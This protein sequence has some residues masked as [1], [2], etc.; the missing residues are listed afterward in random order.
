MTDT[1]TVTPTATETPPISSVVFKLTVRE[2]PI[3]GAPIQ[4]NSTTQ[5]TDRDGQITA[6]LNYGQYYSVSSGVEALSF[7]TLYD[8]GANFIAQSPVS[9]AATRLMSAISGPCRVLV[10]G[11]SNIYFT[12]VNTTERVLS[13]PLTNPSDDPAINL[14]LNSLYGDPRSPPPAPPVDFAPGTTGFAIPESYFASGGGWQFLGQNINV[15]TDPPVCTDRGI[16]GACEVI[17]ARLLRGPFDYTRQVVVNLTK[18]ALKAAKAG[19]WKGGGGA[20]SVPFFK[21][22]G[23]ALA[24]MEKSFINSSGQNFACEVTPMSCRTTKVPKRALARAFA[25]IFE[26][27]VPK[28]LE[29]LQARAKRERKAFDAQLKA[30]PDEYTTCP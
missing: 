23:A 27:K 25:N 6:S 15:A 13:V 5:Y 26:G 2:T 7:S 16:P 24:V 10:G 17:D 1:P 22:G 21:R 8:S 18:D 4:I 19:K 28:G 11:V 9:I 20:F 30:L 29:P 12:C 14:S 3:A